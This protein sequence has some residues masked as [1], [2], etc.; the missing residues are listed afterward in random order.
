MA[1][2][3]MD[4]SKATNDVP[5]SVTFST[6]TETPSVTPAPSVDLSEPHRDIMN[7]T[8]TRA[9]MNMNTTLQ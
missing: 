6:P 7:T 4:S 3:K 5:A 8:G 1:D 9:S 2:T